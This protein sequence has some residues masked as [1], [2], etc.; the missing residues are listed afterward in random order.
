MTPLDKQFD[1]IYKLKLR[2]ILRLIPLKSLR[3]F[4][5]YRKVLFF[6]VRLSSHTRSPNRFIL[7]ADDFLYHTC[8][9]LLMEDIN[10]CNTNDG[11]CKEFKIL[12]QGICIAFVSRTARPSLL[13]LIPLGPGGYTIRQFCGWWQCIVK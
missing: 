5:C 10:E 2:L 1:V 13:E 7:F 9:R 12:A 8:L 6:H 4:S 11:T 3:E